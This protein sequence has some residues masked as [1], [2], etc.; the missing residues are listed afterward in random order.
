VRTLETVIRLSS[1]AAKARLSGQVETADVDVA[2]GLMDYV[3]KSDKA[4]D[5]AA[6]RALM[7]MQWLSLLPSR[8]NLVLT[9]VDNYGNLH[10]VCSPDHGPDHGDGANVQV[11][12]HCNWQNRNS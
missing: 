12:Y 11:F 9:C 2:T 10:S 7:L 8:T 6:R 1:A 5:G 4:A 3:L